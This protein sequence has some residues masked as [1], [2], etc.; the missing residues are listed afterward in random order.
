[1]TAEKVIRESDAWPEVGGVTIVHGGAAGVTRKAGNPEFV[2]ALRVEE[3]DHPLA[4]ERSLSVSYVA[5]V[6][7]SRSEQL[8][9][10]PGVQGEIRG[11]LNVVLKE[12]GVIIHLVFVV[13]NAAS[14]KR[15]SR[16]AQQEIVE[17]RT[18][19]NRHARIAWIR[20]IAGTR[21][22]EHLTIERLREILIQTNSV[23]LAAKTQQMF[24]ERVACSVEEGVIVLKLT[25]V[26]SW[27]RSNLVTAE[28]KLVNSLVQVAVWPIN[29]KIIHI[30]DRGIGRLVVDMNVPKTE[31]VYQPG[32]KQ[33]CLCNA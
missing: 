20:R 14:T 26:R 2:H 17:V 5:K 6:V 1:M 7:F 29:P 16:L 11:D 32:T 18:S 12:Q 23:I 9:P 4:H 30:D 31:F 15:E 28:G 21:K 19:A 24:A 33:M 22:E 3:W 25:L 27:G 10:Q 13:G 8:P